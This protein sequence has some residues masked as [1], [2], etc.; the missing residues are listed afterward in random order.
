MRGEKESEEGRVKR[1]KK[2]EKS[3]NTGFPMFCGSQGRGSKSRLAKAAGAEPSARCRAICPDERW[4][5]QIWKNIYGQGFGALLEVEMWKKCTLLWGEAHLEV[6]MLKH[7]SFGCAK[8]CAPL[9]PE[10]HFEVKNAKNTLAL[11]H[12][13]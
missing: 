9:W 3:R 11:K 1:A 10:T 5:K 2:V 6:N 4:A 12:I 8:K 13:G 7:F